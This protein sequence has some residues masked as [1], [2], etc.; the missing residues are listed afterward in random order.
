M[1]WRIVVQIVIVGLLFQACKDEEGWDPNADY[2]IKLKTNKELIL[3]AKAITSYGGYKE[4]YGYMYQIELDDY[5]SSF[6][7]IRYESLNKNIAT[8]SNSGLIEAQLVGNAKIRLYNFKTSDTI[9]VA[10]NVAAPPVPSMPDGSFD[11]DRLNTL[12][13]IGSNF[14]TFVNEKGQSSI[15]YVNFDEI[16][17]VDT[18]TYEL[19]KIMV[20]R[21][22]SYSTTSNLLQHYGYQTHELN[23]SFELPSE[24]F[25]QYYIQQ[26]H[27]TASIADTS[28]TQT[29]FTD[30]KSIA[31]AKFKL[32]LVQKDYKGK[33]IISIWKTQANYEDSF[34]VTQQ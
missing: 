27:K 16:E 2:P 12:E 3:N 17:V 4:S 23:D 14:E 6:P 8:V 28:Y 19:D 7:P 25:A 33:R 31:D 11:W 21:I 30:S 24:A 15:R 32:H 20:N 1:N 9:N 29:V 22:Y 10:V 26:E 5:P 13:N 18:N 34:W